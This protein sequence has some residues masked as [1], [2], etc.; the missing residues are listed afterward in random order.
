MTTMD[1]AARHEAE[2][3]ATF[4]PHGWSAQITTRRTEGVVTRTVTMFDHH[5]S[6]QEPAV[7]NHPHAQP[8]FG[9]ILEAV[10]E[11]VMNVV[12][13]RLEA[14]GSYYWMNEGHGRGRLGR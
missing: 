14:D 8:H 7:M 2:D 9:T 4:L 6:T 1:D 12:T 11:D 3:V 13:M 5:R 10:H